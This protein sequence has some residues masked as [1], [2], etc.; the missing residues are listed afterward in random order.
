MDIIPM[1]K[2]P[3]VGKTL[4]AIFLLTLINFALAS[5]STLWD[6]DEPLY[7]RTSCEMLQNGEWLL[8]TFNGEVFD[9]KPPLAYWTMAGSVALFGVNTTAVRLPAI[10]FLAVTGWLTF[11]MGRRLYSP[12][13]GFWASAMLMSSAM[14]MYMGTVAMLDATL[15]AFISLA[16]WA[17]IE[18]LHHP[19]RWWAYWPV[20]ALALGLAELTKHPV[21]MATLVPATFLSTWMLRK[22]M[23]IPK[24]YWLGL[25]AA[26][27]AGYALHQAWFIAVR[28]MAPGF[29]EEILGRQ[30]VGR[31]FAAMEGHGADSLLGYLA[32]VPVYVPILLVGF[33]PWSAFLPAG[34]STLIHRHVGER[35]TR[36]F[37]I[38]WALPIFVL[39]SLAATKL[40][41]YILPIF[42][43]AALLAAGTLEAWRNGW[44]D[45]KDHYWLRLG[46]WFLAPLVFGFGVALCVAAPLLGQGLWRVVGVLPGVLV[47]LFGIFVFRLIR[48]E[49]MMVVAR[50][51]LV[52]MPLIL[53][54]SAL[55][56]L[57]TIEPLIKVSPVLAQTIQGGRSPGEPV[58][59]CGYAEPSFIFYMN[60]PADQ[61]IAVLGRDPKALRA[62]V[63]E[64]GPGWLVVY[65]SLWQEMI[66]RFGP[67]AR[68]QTRGKVPVLNTNDRA[69]RDQVR[70]VR[71]FSST[72]NFSA[73]EVSP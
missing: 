10:F 12:H 26:C 27:A 73:K 66:D 18:A 68:V 41:H 48:R 58:S 28:N 43:P 8:P 17:H 11:L 38:S 20:L 9:H 71:R 22:D 63:G 32:L 3:Y 15:M 67:V 4:L 55:L 52:G 6:R 50:V 7:A 25:V 49:R 54:L 39:F 33:A 29:S 37:L 16:M 40:P 72:E 1:L 47:L 64:Q 62:W 45:Q 35:T 24:C 46:A 36:V 30:I 13:V 51:L 31:F 65:D 23:Q 44:L 14:A 42:P 53:L 60:L 5:Q 70:V 2:Q 19:A 56:T 57:P 34:V 21:G 69:R 61:S 59:M